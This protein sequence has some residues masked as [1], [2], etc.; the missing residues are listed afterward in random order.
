MAKLEDLTNGS[1]VHGLLSGEPVTVV[2]TK[3]YGSSS[4]E[5]IFKTNHGTT[6]S[7]IL[8]R[9]DEPSLDVLEK[10]LPWSFDV[11]GNK[12][13]LVSEAYR[14]HLAHLFDPYLAVH[15]SAIEPLPH[16][17]S[18][19][20]EEMLPRLPLRYVLADDPGAGKTIMTGLLLKEL[21]IRG[22]LKRCLIVSPGNLAEQWQ[23]ELFQKFH[24]RFEILTNDRLESAVTGNIF[25]EVNFCIARLDKL[26]RNAELQE[27]LKV[28]DW[29]LIVCDEAHKMSATMWGGEVKYTKRYQ[30]GRLLSSITRHF[31]LLTLEHHP[32][33]RRCR[34]ADRRCRSRRYHRYAQRMDRLQ[35]SCIPD[36]AGLQLCGHTDELLQLHHRCCV[37]GSVPPDSRAGCFHRHQPHRPVCLHRAGRTEL[38]HQP[39]LLRRFPDSW[40]L[41]SGGRA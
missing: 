38:R 23:D 32:D 41:Q 4:V 36:S 3:W 40:F 35:C 19:V 24:L 7:Q 28:T 16:Q 29:D 18:A 13:R 39:L 2:S 9:E 15:T 26:A 17:I 14:I 30:L 37:S 5:V 8:Y 1:V 21:I 34:Y 25:T 31:L 33:D 10:S 27:K 6:G 22:D 11:D 12:L 20:Y